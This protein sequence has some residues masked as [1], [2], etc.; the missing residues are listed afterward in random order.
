MGVN[1]SSLE[2]HI[3]KIKNG[4]I[5]NVNVSVKKNIIAGILDM[6]LQEQ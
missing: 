5:I 4:K 3:I 2:Q 1:E 6:Y